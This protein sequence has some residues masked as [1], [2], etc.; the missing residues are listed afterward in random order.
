[1]NEQI[2]ETKNNFEAQWVRTAINLQT[3]RTTEALG[4]KR[5]KIF[6]YREAGKVAREI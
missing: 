2:Y 5:D 3:G 4:W 1:V 6:F